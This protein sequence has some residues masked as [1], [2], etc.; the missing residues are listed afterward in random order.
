MHSRLNIECGRYMKLKVEDRLCTTCNATED[1]THVICQCT[2][3][4]M[5][6]NQMNQIITEKKIPI[7]KFS[8]IY[9]QALILIY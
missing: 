6:R 7:Q 8:K 4:E 9:D 3:F 2:T 1:E 5:S